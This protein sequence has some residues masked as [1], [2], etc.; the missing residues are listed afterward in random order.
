M[1]VTTG[2]LSYSLATTLLSWG[3]LMLRVC[4]VTVFFSKSQEGA[5]KGA[6]HGEREK[7]KIHT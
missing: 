1:T 5:A 2:H 4:E 3:M 7:Q 6:G